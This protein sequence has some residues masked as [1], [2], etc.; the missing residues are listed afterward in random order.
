V[1]VFLTSASAQVRPR[2]I[3]VGV[4]DP[5]GGAVLDLQA[6]DFQI[7]ELGVPR[8]VSTAALANTP[9]R[10]ALLVDTSD[11]ASPHLNN[12]RAGL[13]AFL[14]ALPPE[15]EIA[16]I[17]TGRQLRVREQPTTDRKKLK[18]TA[19]QLFTDNGSGTVLLDSLLETLDRFL[20]KP[21]DRWGVFVVLTTDGDEGSSVTNDR[22]Q[23]FGRDLL[24][25]ASTVHAIVL[26]NRGDGLP[27]EVSVG[28]TQHT[29]GHYDAM[30]ASNALPEKMKA[31]ADL[32]AAEHGKM[33]TR[34]RV[35]FMSGAADPLAKVDVTVQRPGVKIDISPVRRFQ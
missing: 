32:M 4:T 14:D 25:R 18:T 15:H 24:D 31:L 21:E 26:S 28:L 33:S 34:Y 9:M 11:A 23:R 22:F 1:A 3:F 5:G 7:Q 17:T 29:G 19:G 12:V 16:L 30:A 35:T 2:Q 13:Q 20:R 6:A 10:V 27:T 8:L